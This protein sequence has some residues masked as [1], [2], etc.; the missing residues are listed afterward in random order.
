MCVCRGSNESS[1]EA[2]ATSVALNKFTQQNKAYLA[3]HC[4][5]TNV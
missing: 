4:Y 5:L 1:A 3:F 2:A